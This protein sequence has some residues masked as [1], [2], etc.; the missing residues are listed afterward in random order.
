MHSN[1]DKMIEI[2]ECPVCKSTKPKTEIS[3]KQY[4]LYRC[5]K[6]DLVYVSPIVSESS[7]LYTYD[8]SS[9]TSIYYS[10]SGNSDSM[11]F[12]S[13]L[14]LIE[15][16]IK[17][18]NLLD[19]GCSVGT[20]L[21]TAKSRGW[22]VTGVEPNPNSAALCKEKGI[23]VFNCFFDKR[24]AEEHYEEYDAVYLGDVIEHV[25]DAAALISNTLDVMKNG[26]V[27]MIITPD[28]ESRTARYFQIKPEEH[29]L[30]FNIDSISHLLGKFQLKIEEIG[31]TTRSRDLRALQFSSTFRE[32]AGLMRG[33]KI[34]SMFRLNRLINVFIRAFVRDEII[35]LLRKL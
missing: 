5:V 23:T 31:R 8:D 1:H 27:L 30:Y 17:R 10:N 13:R 26:G 14:K 4:T 16:Y 11:T 18:G 15:K 22:M 3:K 6:C 32:R 20:M 34:L 21:N 35:V 25:H 24:F 12:E 2:T 9:S 28:F 19:I 33:V 7:S 29:L